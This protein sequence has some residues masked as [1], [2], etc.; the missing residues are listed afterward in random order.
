MTDANMW[1]LFYLT[2]VYLW[3]TLLTV[4]ADPGHRT[5]ERV[6]KIL[7]V[8]G[9]VLGA[10][11]IANGILVI[12]EGYYGD[13][14]WNALFDYSNLSVPKTRAARG[15]I[16]LPLFSILLALFPLAIIAFGGWGVFIYAK[17]FSGKTTKSLEGKGRQGRS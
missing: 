14:R 1:H 9:M 12:S 5:R 10:L 11:F 16:L 13:F 4:P 3:A 8:G 6:A 17:L 15:I 2:P 7:A